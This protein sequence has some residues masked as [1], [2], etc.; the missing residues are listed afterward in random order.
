MKTSELYELSVWRGIGLADLLLT[1][2][3]YDFD[4]KW[5]GKRDTSQAIIYSYEDYAFFWSS[6][7]FNDAYSDQP[8]NSYYGR[9]FAEWSESIMRAV[10]P[11]W[12]GCSIRCI[13]E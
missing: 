3:A 10:L 5:S 12:Y 7:K 13:K 11:G 9:V 4:V 8:Y 2:G 1:D 6:T